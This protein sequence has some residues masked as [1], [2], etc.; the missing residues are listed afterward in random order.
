MIVS[1]QYRADALRMRSLIS[2]RSSQPTNQAIVDVVCPQVCCCCHH[3]LRLQVQPHPRLR[4]QIPAL[5]AVA[6][7][8]KL[9]QDIHGTRVVDNHPVFYLSLPPPYLFLI[10]NPS[11]DIFYQITHMPKRLLNDEK[12]TPPARSR[13]NTSLNAKFRSAFATR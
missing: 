10:F 11:R 3:Q 12:L 6:Q 2:L 7:S 8:Q 9:V 4:S 5:H 13:S 1:W